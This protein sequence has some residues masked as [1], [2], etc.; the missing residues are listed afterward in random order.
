MREAW[1]IY[2]RGLL[3]LAFA[4]LLNGCAGIAAVQ[5]PGAVERY[6]NCN[7]EQAMRR[8]SSEGD[9][10]QLAI[11]A[12]ASCVHE[13]LGVARVY[14]RSVGTE[15]AGILLDGI[16]QATIASNAATIAMDGVR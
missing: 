16:R 4:T 12:E 6:V 10:A 11:E 9:A 15:Q 8:A 3:G 5:G 7:T 14:Q 1:M 13:R 2:K